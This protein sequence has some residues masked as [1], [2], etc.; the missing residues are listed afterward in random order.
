M[1]VGDSDEPGQKGAEAL[2]SE[3]V[4]YC[5]SVR[6]VYPPDGVKDLRQWKAKGLAKEQL[7]QAICH[8][9]SVGV[10]ISSA[11]KNKKAQVRHG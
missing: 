2:A 9:A 3:L 6:L 1:I 5:P 10:R 11:I 4:L 8:S 7:E